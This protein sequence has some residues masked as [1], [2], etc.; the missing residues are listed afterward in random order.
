MTLLLS[1]AAQAADNV[2]TMSS[3]AFDVTAALNNTKTSVSGPFNNINNYPAPNK[4]RLTTSLLLVV[5]AYDEYVE[6][7]WSSNAF[8]KDAKLVFMDDKDNFTNSYFAVIDSSGKQLL[9]VSD[10]L[11]V[12][13]STEDV[14]ESGHINVATDLLSNYVTTSAADFVFDDTE[15][16][17]RFHFDLNGVGADKT[18]DKVKNHVRTRAE[19]I[20]IKPAIGF[21]AI[22]DR[23]AVLI[24][25]VTLSGSETFYFN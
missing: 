3:V 2:F 18:N 10:L 11:S 19:S 23:P 20:T 5:I 9:D 8:P 22:G 1:I 4:Y 7:N 21:G 24:G 14:L 6:G 25:S 17:G 13:I 16:G 15:A 12:T